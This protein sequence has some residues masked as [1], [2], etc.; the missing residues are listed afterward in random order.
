[1]LA[2]GTEASMRPNT[3]LRTWREGGSTVGGWLTVAS[4]FNAEVMAH[5]GFDWLC[6]DMQHGLIDFSDT[7]PMLQ[8]ISQTE[9]VPIV[10][11]GWNDPALIM[12]VLD[13]GAY[14]VVVP[15]VNT[16]EEAER[17]VGACRYPP[18]G[19]R[20]AGPARARLYGGSDYVEAANDEIACIVMIE[21]AEA[22]ANLDEVLSTPGVDACYV[23][24]ADLALGLGLPGRGDN[25]DPRHLEAVRSILDACRRHGVT[26]GIHTG[27]VEYASKYLE[28][29]FQMV[30][31]GSDTGWMTAR[32][33]FD[34]AAVRGAVAAGAV[35]PE[36]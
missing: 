21:T 7:L 6:I 5:V 12:K 30:T 23:G 13:G 20:S 33:A 31:L 1:M 22:L 2:A 19:Y 25:P 10:R 34:L 8:A 11:V 32:A 29:G 26:P 17:A 15:M 18:R 36:A 35:T 3:M 27:S 24:P 14:G 28:L 16:H 9:V 4:S